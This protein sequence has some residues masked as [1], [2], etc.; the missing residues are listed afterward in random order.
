MDFELSEE[1]RLLKE[2]ASRFLRDHYPLETRQAH[3]EEPEGFN[4]KAW[5]EFADL[6]L[7]AA[8]LP[9]DVGGLGGDGEDFLVMFEELGRAL[10]VE[11]FLASAVLGAT[12]I[13]LTGSEAQRSQT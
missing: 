5:A 7:I 9:P 12:P 2:T 10:V 13:S 1:R 4:R 6:G 8:L 11:P 3:A